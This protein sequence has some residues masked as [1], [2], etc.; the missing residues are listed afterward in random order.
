MTGRRALLIDDNDDH[1]EWLAGA[2]RDRSW[3]VVA[4]RGGKAAL[5]IAP[6]QRP[7]VIIC[8]LILPDVQGLQLARAFRTALDHDVTIIAAT[9]VPDLA[10]QALAAT[11]DHVLGKPVDLVE[12]FARVFA[13]SP[14]ALINRP[15]DRH[16]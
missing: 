11:Y 16:L 12:L 6:Q 15:F 7:D 13:P 2:L 5:G 1:R 14:R 9:R 3:D 8:E 10:P 4:L